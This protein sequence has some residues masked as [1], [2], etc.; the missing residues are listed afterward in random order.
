MLMFAGEVHGEGVCFCA[1]KVP[2]DRS[3]RF[4]TDSCKFAT[5]S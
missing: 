4:S 3:L 2:D 1:V 5:L